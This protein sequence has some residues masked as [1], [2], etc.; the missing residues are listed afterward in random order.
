MDLFKTKPFLHLAVVA[1]S[2]WL[3][4][5]G[6]TSE[7]PGIEVQKIIEAIEVFENQS[8]DEWSYNFEENNKGTILFATCLPVSEGGNQILKT[9]NGKEPS[10]EE[11]K[12]FKKKHRN[13]KPKKEGSV[14]N[15]TFGLIDRETLSFESRVGSLSEFKFAPKLSFRDTPETITEMDGFLVYNNLNNYI[16]SLRVISTKPFKPQK[17]IKIKDFEFKS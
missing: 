13:R 11:I 14:Q 2:F 17:G 7:Q 10:T 4:G 16:E 12:K 8:L 3:S 15:A 5:N 1:L 9:I 6:V